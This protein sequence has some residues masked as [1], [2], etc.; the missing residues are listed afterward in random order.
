MV[1]LPGAGTSLA[2]SPDNTKLY[3]SSADGNVTVIDTKTRAVVKTIQVGGVPTGVAVSKE[4]SAS[5]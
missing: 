1:E 4:G 5:W 2:I 3:V